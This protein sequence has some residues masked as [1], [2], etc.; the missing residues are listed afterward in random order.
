MI[1]IPAPGGRDCPRARD[2]LH[3]FP[4]VLSAGAG[5]LVTGA[6]RAAQSNSM[7]PISIPQMADRPES[8]FT[9]TLPCIQNPSTATH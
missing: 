1:D 9:D 3:E 5:E 2:E 8:R 4:E 7:Q 6:T